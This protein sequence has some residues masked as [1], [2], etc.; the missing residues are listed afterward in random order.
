MP[1]QPKRL[2]FQEAIDSC[3]AFY[4]N[5]ALEDKFDQFIDKKFNEIK[6]SVGVY[7]VKEITEDKLIAFLR[8]ETSALRRVLGQLQLSQEKFL[9]IITLLRKLDGSFEREWSIVVNQRNGTLFEP[10]TLA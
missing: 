7:G 1:Q 3:V 10:N 4:N 6:Q 5:E 8:S 2:T 9:R